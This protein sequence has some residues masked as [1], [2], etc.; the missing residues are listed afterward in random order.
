M[1]YRDLIQ[2]ILDYSDNLD[3]EVNLVLI[4]NVND[5]LTM[6]YE[7]KIDFVKNDKPLQDF[8]RIHWSRASSV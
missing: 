6:P 7:V 3:D 5:K 4:D 1:T 2:K 8:M